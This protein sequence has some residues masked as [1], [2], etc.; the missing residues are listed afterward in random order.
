M[1]LWGVQ[2]RWLRVYNLIF[3]SGQERQNLRIEWI[4][5]ERK[6]ERRRWPASP[7]LC[8]EGPLSPTPAVTGLTVETVTVCRGCLP[9][10]LRAPSGSS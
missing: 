1:V 8:F 2:V 10:R 4:E 3:L 9:A 5:T 6:S 7:L